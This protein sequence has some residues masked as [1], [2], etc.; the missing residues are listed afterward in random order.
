MRIFSVYGYG[1]HPMT[2][3]NTLVKACIAGEDFSL[4]PCTQIWNF[5]EARDAGAAIAALCLAPELK[6]NVY[7]IAGEENRPLRD[8][9]LEIKRIC[10]GAG[11]LNFGARADNAE[12]AVDLNPDISGLRELGFK[13]K[14]SFEEGIRELYERLN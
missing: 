9:V 5:L 2:L 7:D 14:Y 4:G 6:R 1:D 8:Y 13:E 10:G 3:V 12:G 11:K